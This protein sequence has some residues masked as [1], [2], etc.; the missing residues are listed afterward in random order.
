MFNAVKDAS[1]KTNVNTV[2]MPKGAFIGAK[3]LSNGVG[4]IIEYDTSRLNCSL[5]TVAIP[6]FAVY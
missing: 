6:P 4:L 2:L 3:K 1:Q 5:I